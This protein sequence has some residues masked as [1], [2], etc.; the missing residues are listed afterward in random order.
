M[1]HQLVL[2]RGGVCYTTAAIATSRV[3]DVH[4]KPASPDS[5][6]IAIAQAQLGPTQK[7]CTLFQIYVSLAPQLSHRP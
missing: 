7:V 6:L 5:F 3:R 4:L 2:G 1:I